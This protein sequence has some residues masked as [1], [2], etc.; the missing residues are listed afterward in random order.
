M[1]LP[2][3]F[4]LGSLALIPTSIPVWLIRGRTGV[5]F[6]SVLAAPVLATIPVFVGS[7]I[8]TVIIKNAKDVNSWT[9]QPAQLPLGIEVSAGP[10]F[11][12]AWLAFC[13]LAASAIGPTIKSAL[14]FRLIFTTPEP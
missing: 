8:W 2:T 13:F 11:Y 5:L 6:V 12:C 10:G 4:C 3:N 1:I 9:V 14:F 7:V